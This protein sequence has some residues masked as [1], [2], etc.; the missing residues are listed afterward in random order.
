MITRRTN[1]SRRRNASSAKVIPLF[2]GC[3]EPADE[4]V[5][6]DA[7]LLEGIAKRDHKAFATLVRRHA[8]RFFRVAYRFIGNPSESEDMVQ[9]AF[10]KLWE[11]PGL[12]Q[13]N[14]NAAFTTWF[15]RIVVNQCLDFMKK[16]RPVQLEDDSW[17]EDEGQ[18]HEENMLEYEKQRLLELQIMKLPERQRTALNLCF[19]EGLSN[20][21]AAEI[22]G[23]HIKALQALLMR[24]KT[25]L[26]VELR[27]MTG[28]DE[29]AG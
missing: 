8:A 12:W 29:Y 21:Q 5:E 28:G 19:Y 4:V 9:D 24:A 22:M 14:R 3:V 16:K 6:S 20:R 27:F 26:K 15:Y 17:V 18:T 11:R 10:L 23:I 1:I 13:A 25:A 7:R 2:P